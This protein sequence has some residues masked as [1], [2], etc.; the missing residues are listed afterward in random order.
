MGQEALGT[1][2]QTFFSEFSREETFCGPPVEGQ[3]CPKCGDS[4]AVC[5]LTRCLGPL[6]LAALEFLEVEL[7]ANQGNRMLACIHADQR[8]SAKWICPSAS[9]LP[10]LWLWQR[11]DVPLRPFV[12][13]GDGSGCQGGGIGPAASTRRGPWATILS[14]S[15]PKGAGKMGPARQLSKSVGKLF[16][17][18]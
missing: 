7:E 14:Q 3:R 2:F 8:Y 18:F 12:H 15:P 4:I 10:L 1:P 9:C 6:C 17:A 5:C 13:Y 16:D 11:E